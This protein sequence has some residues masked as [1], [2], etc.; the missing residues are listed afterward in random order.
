MARTST[1]EYERALRVAQVTAALDLMLRDMAR[2]DHLGVSL[3]RDA[4]LADTVEW[5]LRREERIV[6]A[7]HNGHVQRYPVAVPGVPPAATLGMH[8]ADRLGA[9]YRVVGTTTAAGRTLNTGPGFYAGE[10]FTDLDGAPRPGSLD[11]LLAASHDGPYAVDLRR[12]GPADTAALRAVDSQRFGAFHTD[13][14]PLTAYD[15]VVHLPVV[16]AA[17]PDPDA[18]AHAPA[19]VRAAMG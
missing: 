19:D 12:L 3:T 11:A 14:D 13:Q 4:A 10:L 5:I 2:G 6:P 15:L 16:T 18:L 9:A 7:A 1:G 8:L 17:D